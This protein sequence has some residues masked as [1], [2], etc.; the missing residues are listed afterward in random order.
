MKWSPSKKE[1][2]FIS[3]AAKAKVFVKPYISQ[4]GDMADKPAFFDFAMDFLHNEWELIETHEA[5]GSSD[6]PFNVDVCGL[7]GLFFV[8]APEFSLEPF[9]TNLEDAQNEAE[10]IYLNYS[11][12]E[13][14]SE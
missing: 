11:Q 12:P 13:S 10:D 3:K 4:G 6:G 7:G 9:H 8:L 2:E 5:Y 1:M 14:E